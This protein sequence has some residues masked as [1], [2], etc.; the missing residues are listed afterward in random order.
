MIANHHIGS[1]GARDV[2]VLKGANMSFRKAAVVE[3][4]FDERLLGR[5]S[6]VHSELSICLPLRRRGLR[7]VYDPGIVVLH[8][9]AP[10]PHGD[11]RGSAEQVFSA[12]HNEALQIL[13]YFGPAR[14]IVFL[15]WGLAIGTTAAPGL[16]VLAR[17]VLTGR[18]AAWDRFTA[19]QRGRAAGWKTR[20]TPRVGPAPDD[21]RT[22]LQHRPALGW[23]RRH[24]F[25]A[26]RLRPAVAEHSRAEAVLL[27][28]Y[29]AGVR[30]I[31]E[32][33]VAEG[34]SAAELRSVMSPAGHLYLVDPYE[35][36]R[37]GVSMARITARRTVNRVG[38]GRVRWLRTRSDQAIHNWHRPVDFLFIDADHSYSATARDWHLWT[39]FVRDGGHVAMHDSAV[40]PGGWT[41]DRSGPVR[42]LQEIRTGEPRWTLVDQADSLSILRNDAQA[43][44]GGDR[45]GQDRGGQ[46]RGG[47]DRKLNV[48]RVIDVPGTETAGGSGYVLSSTTE[49][50]RQGHHVSLWFRDQ[51]APTICSSGLR[52]L[53]VPWVIVAKVFAAV[54]RGERF[55]VVEIHEPMSG[56]YGLAARFVGRRLPT[57]AVLSFGLE[58]RGWQARLA[59]LR[60]H[61][62]K[63]PLRSRALVPLTL[64]SQARVGVRA[65]ETVV[66]PSSADRDYL[67]GRLGVPGERVSCAFTGV[68]E[69]LFKVQRI[70]DDDVRL[71]FLGSW[72]ERKGTHELI[73]AWRRLAV[74][75][76]NV[77]LTVAGTGN[78]ER[79]AADLNG[80][81]R[82]QLIPI[83]RRDELAG[84]LARQD[85]FVLASWFEGMP[86]SMLEAA[87]AGLACVV[88]SVS[89]NLDVFRLDDPQRDGAVL[90]P[91][92][93]ADALYRALLTLV[94]DDELRGALG[95]RARERARRFSW[96][97]T[98]Q[99]ELTAFQAA[100]RQRENAWR[101]RS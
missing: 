1:G 29:A 87:A 45:G 96:A 28:R 18:R 21:P 10:R 24:V 25:G 69:A 47:Q 32:L 35:R 58:E 55:D 3:Q 17:D 89:G 78:A 41:G 5:G 27:M 36:G 40:F 71:L 51:L 66:V 64:L 98:A 11:H 43:V 60:A 19:A 50:E 72:I 65:A 62:R 53:L 94:D 34:G 9:P 99:Q 7:V 101:W 88:C 12:S 14:R 30:T 61:G 6:Q 63:P 85:V 4:G 77:R 16:A 79:A 2:D 81:P 56:P 54:R 37:L 91:P 52:R 90:I 44:V 74:S 46:D 38:R 75:R 31:V 68:S 33:G 83:V 23:R 73:A 8:Y 49:M 26:L 42:L 70:A 57:C 82:A 95:A 22:R 92:N 80:L 97:R 15:A 100:V 93:D 76:G 39:P 84:L 86:L 20:R 59:Y 48:L 13:D 67:I